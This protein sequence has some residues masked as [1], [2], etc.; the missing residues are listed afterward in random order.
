[1]KTSFSN[2]FKRIATKQLPEEKIYGRVSIAKVFADSSPIDPESIFVIEPFDETFTSKF[3]STLLVNPEMKAEYDTIFESISAAR[4]K[5]IVQLNKVSKVKKDDIENTILKDF[6]MT[7]F[8]EFM[9]S[10]LQAIETADDFGTVAYTAIFDQKVLDILAQPDVASNF[11]S[12][13]EKYNELVSTVGYYVKGGFS[14][15]K[16]DNVV[17]TLQREKYF[18]A[19]NSVILNGQDGPIFDAR[20]LQEQ[21]END[22]SKIM[23]NA[24]LKKIGDTVISSVAAVRAFQELVEEN[25]I[26]LPELGDV[27]A[28]R[29]KLWLSYLK[30]D[31][32]LVR[33]CSDAY[34]NGEVRMRSIEERAKIELTRW[35]E[36]TKIFKQRFDVPFEIEIQD[37]VNTILG[38]KS[39]NIVFVF[40]DS[41]DGTRRTFSK[42]AIQSLKVL[43]QGER[44]AMYLLQVIF[45]V[46]SRRVGSSQTLFV[47]DDIAD[48]FDYRNKYAIIEYLKDMNDERFFRLLVL[49]HNFDFFRTVQGRIV[50]DAKWTNSFIALKE[51][52]T[53]SLIPA[54]NKAAT[55][56]FESWKGQLRTNP[57]MVVA[58][59]PFVRNIVEYKEGSTHQDYKTLTAL[60][61]IKPETDTITLSDLDSIFGRYLHNIDLGITGRE[62]EKVANM[63]F[64]TARSIASAP[65]SE[66]TEIDLKVTL[67]MAIRLLAETY[68]WE[69]V[70]DKTPI[71]GSQTGKL[72]DRF[73]REHSEDP[74]KNDVI[75]TLGAVNLM[76]PE[77]I[78]LNSF[79]Y[80]PIL[81]MSSKH[82]LD[83]YDKVS[84]L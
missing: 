69:N 10:H 35:F 51:D 62:T 72:F 63:L 50:G 73:K 18:E 24:D 61:H 17:K 3:V 14:P 60:L 6:K 20:S 82:L 19:K 84:R 65:K 39:P 66:S 8:F 70:S 43:S 34:R 38:T 31:I 23:Q 80:E 44:R 75:R 1:M 68:M 52:S 76:T 29:T 5:L 77:N 28:F 41:N 9:D 53:V 11:S 78:H 42:D 27:E 49:S 79:M 56:P 81:D 37:Q 33:D 13:I 47:I 57:S 64:E 32:Q 25:P 59:I 74:T 54:G 26:I 83:L 2:T 46:E 15:L 7:N 67:S 71:G 36:V 4:T 45:D 22:K 21:I 58:S 40:S 12:Y 48:S 55:S 30:K 16:A